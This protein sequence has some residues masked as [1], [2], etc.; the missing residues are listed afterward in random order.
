MA[1][2]RPKAIC[3]FRHGGKVLLVDSFDPERHGRF[4]IPVGGGVEFGEYSKDAAARETLEEIQGTAIN[5]KLL[6]IIENIFT[7][8]GGAG[9]E[10]VFVY[11]GDLVEQELYT[12][13]EIHGDENGNLLIARWYAIDWLKEGHLPVYPDGILEIL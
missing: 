11:E 1:K 8:N 7:F 4:L 12:A 2:I 10:V 5:L 13:E 3:I 9:H 6:T